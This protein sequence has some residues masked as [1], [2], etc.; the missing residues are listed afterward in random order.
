MSPQMKENELLYKCRWVPQ[1]KFLCRFGHVVVFLSFPFSCSVT[2][3]SLGFKIIL[4]VQIFSGCRFWFAELPLSSKVRGLYSH[5]L[6][7][8]SHIYVCQVWGGL[9]KL[10]CTSSTAWKKKSRK[11]VHETG[12]RIPIQEELK[13][14]SKHSFHPFTKSIIRSLLT[15]SD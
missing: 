2:E 1:A 13:Q 10:P 6:P 15:K 5:L 4:R 3:C 8:I 7:P 14:D 11:K 9:W 12:Q